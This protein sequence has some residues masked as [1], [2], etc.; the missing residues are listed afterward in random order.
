VGRERGK[1]RE[2]GYVLVLNDFVASLSSAS[3]LDE[4]IAAAEDGDGVFTDVAE[5]DVC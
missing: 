4:G 3:A 5:P 2:R 1:G